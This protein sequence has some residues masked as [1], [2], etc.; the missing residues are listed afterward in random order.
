MDRTL[1]Q[2]GASG[3]TTPRGIPPP[4]SKSCIVNRKCSALACV[5][6]TSTLRERRHSSPI[7]TQ[8]HGTGVLLQANRCHATSP[9]HSDVGRRLR[10][11]VEDVLLLGY[12]VVTATRTQCL[13]L[14]TDC[15]QRY[16]VRRRDRVLA[17]GTPRKVRAQRNMIAAR[18]QLR[19]VVTAGELSKTWA[20]CCRGQVS[21][22]S[23]TPVYTLR[24]KQI[25]RSTLTMRSSTIAASVAVLVS[26]A[27]LSTSAS[28]PITSQSQGAVPERASHRGNLAHAELQK[29][30]PKFLNDA[31]ACAY[32]K[33]PGNA[34]RLY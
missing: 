5:S 30:V 12:K 1:S 9:R 21:S 2:R 28:T 10:T 34:E 4:S 19:S 7:C 13:P 33:E 6:V 8:C 31:T 11:I 24:S 18:L 14:D 16:T 25:Q 23:S 20:S 26:W 22:F 3:A 29:R 27:C 17:S 15:P 32:S